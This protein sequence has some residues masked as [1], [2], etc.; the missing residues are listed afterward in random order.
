MNNHNLP[1]LERIEF[2]W[3]LF[4]NSLPG[5]T[6]AAP[7]LSALVAGPTFQPHNDPHRASCPTDSSCDQMLYQPITRP[8]GQRASCPEVGNDGDALVHPPSGS[9]N[10]H[11]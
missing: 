6:P 10:S 5:W 7:K 2:S 4:L 11:R 8:E 9:G 3:G 1:R